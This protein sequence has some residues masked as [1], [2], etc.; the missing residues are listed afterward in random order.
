M[1]K[2]ILNEISKTKQEVYEYLTSIYNAIYD[3]K[4]SDKNIE[5]LTETI[6]KQSKMIDE[7]LTNTY[8]ND[9]QFEAVVFV[10]YRGKPYIFKDG[11]RVGF[12][13]MTGFNVDWNCDRKTELT[14]R[15]D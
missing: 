13:S 9:T 1:S 5:L 15:N 6:H 11:K 3:K 14:I 10:P 8:E 12:D 2:K 4:R 7:I